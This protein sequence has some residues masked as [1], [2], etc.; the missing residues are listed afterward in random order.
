MHEMRRPDQAPGGSRIAR[1]LSW[2]VWIADIRGLWPHLRVH[3]AVT[4]VLLPMAGLVAAV[5]EVTAPHAGSLVAWELLAGA[6]VAGLLAWICLFA[7]PLVTR[8]KLPGGRNLADALARRQMLRRL[9]HD[10]RQA[11]RQWRDSPRYERHSH[12]RP[13]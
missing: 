7:A 9:A 1:L 13:R 10:R 4:G 11:L 8:G 5:A 3:F 12:R 6:S 2:S